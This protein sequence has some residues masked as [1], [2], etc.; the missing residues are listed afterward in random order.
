MGIRFK[1][2]AFLHSALPRKSVNMGYIFYV[3]LGVILYGIAAF[4]RKI[5]VDHINPYQIQLVSCLLHALLIPLFWY[6]CSGIKGLNV[7]GVTM[8][9]LTT[10]LG[11]GGGIAFSYLLRGNVN[12]GV[13]SAILGLSPIVTF[14]ISMIIFH[15]SISFWKMIAFLL[16]LLSV[17]LVNF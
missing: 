11:I 7:V 14:T 8:A 15:D 1:Y 2:D 6:L 12:A 13:V 17:I 10:V 4:T 5:S 9:S 16:A 3:L